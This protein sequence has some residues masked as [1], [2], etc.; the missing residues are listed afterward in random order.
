MINSSEQVFELD[1]DLDT[2]V[3]WLQDNRDWAE[4]ISLAH[5]KRN[6]LAKAILS[7][8]GLLFPPRIS[9]CSVTSFSVKALV[10]FLEP[11]AFNVVEG[12]N[13]LEIK[14]GELTNDATEMGYVLRSNRIKSAFRSIIFRRNKSKINKTKQFSERYLAAFICYIKS[15]ELP[16]ARRLKNK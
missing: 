6:P 7:I 4:K 11:I 13:A 8:Q 16:P 1:C 10:Y 14:A 3:C 9:V 15:V 5:T 2:L 12:K